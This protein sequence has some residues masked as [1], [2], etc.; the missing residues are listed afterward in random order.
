[1]TGQRMT[2]ITL[3]SAALDAEDTDIMDG[4]SL[5]HLYLQ[6]DFHIYNYDSDQEPLAVANR[7][8]WT[9]WRRAAATQELPRENEAV[10]HES[11]SCFMKV[12]VASSKQH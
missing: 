5:H 6:T 4:P 1:M 2:S 9:L 8:H 3:L 12:N 11:I 10:I 7:D